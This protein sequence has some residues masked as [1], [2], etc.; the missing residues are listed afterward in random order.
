MFYPVPKCK[1]NPGGFDC[2]TCKGF[3]TKGICSHVV[4]MNHLWRLYNIK[5]HLSKIPKTK[6]KGG[7]QR[8]RPPAAR[9]RLEPTVDSDAESYRSV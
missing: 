5:Y 1:G 8:K 9:E 7:G 2:P 6:A 3:K 4:A